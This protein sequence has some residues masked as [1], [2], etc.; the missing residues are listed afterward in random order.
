MLTA[1]RGLQFHDVAAPDAAIP[2][3]S[4]LI[5]AAERLGD[6]SFG[7][8]TSLANPLMYVGL[9]L[10]VL[11]LAGARLSSLGF[12]RGRHIG[13]VLLLWSLVPVLLFAYVLLA[14][15][16]TF[17][18]LAARLVNNALSNGFFEEFLFRG[19]LQTRLRYLWRPAWAVVVQ[20]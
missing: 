8:S 3:W 5:A 11:L 16:L 14:G 6:Q 4:P 18:R 12:G 9:P 7:Q 20:P 2:L 1:W 19:A 10:P 13:R 17:G 15:Q